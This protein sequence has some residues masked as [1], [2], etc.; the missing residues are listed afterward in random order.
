ML[1]MMFL[2]SYAHFK[3]ILNTIKPVS[4]QFV[5]DNKDICS[6]LSSVVLKSDYS[7]TGL[8]I[9]HQRFRESRSSTHTD[10]QLITM[11]YTCCQNHP[12]LTELIAPLPL[13]L[14]EA[15]DNM[16]YV[17]YPTVQS[18]VFNYV[19][20]HLSSCLFLIKL[21]SLNRKFKGGDSAFIEIHRCQN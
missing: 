15:A 19:H 20:E 14:E 6:V 9:L 13:P 12:C 10:T 7:D 11:A 2:Q 17:I 16:C 3:K 18:L 4:S 1:L 8:V 21:V 5:A